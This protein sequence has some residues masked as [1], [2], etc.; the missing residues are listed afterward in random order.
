[1]S[2]EVE[3]ISQLFKN[4]KLSQ[5]RRGSDS[6]TPGG[7]GKTFQLGPNTQYTHA[8]TGSGGGAGSAAHAHTMQHREGSPG[9]GSIGLAQNG[10]RNCQLHVPT[11][12]LAAERRGS[13]GNMPWRKGG[14][15]SPSPSPTAQA[16]GNGHGHAHPGHLPH[17]L[18]TD[19][20][21]R[22]S[23]PGDVL[24]FPRKDSRKFSQDSIDAS[25]QKHWEHDGGAIIEE[26]VSTASYFFIAI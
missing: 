6:G 25:E 12:G 9:P 8:H 24:L 4:V 21:R 2:T 22:G 17:H 7:G 5:Q 16:G 14:S 3:R 1:M 23:T 10:S 13:T 18:Q 20:S 15:P 26:E 19:W 11:A